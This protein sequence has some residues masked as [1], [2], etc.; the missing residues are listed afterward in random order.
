MTGKT[1]F[2]SLA[3]VGLGAFATAAEAQVCIGFPNQPAQAAVALSSN[4]P[5]D[6]DQF[7]V[8]GSMNLEGPLAV[9]A[10][11]QRTTARGQAGG[12][13]NT[14]RAG[15]ALEVTERYVG[16]FALH[17]SACPTVSASLTRM[18]GAEVWQVPLGVGIG[19]RIEAG[20][21]G[22][23]EFMPYA[24]PQLVW[25]RARVEQGV[26]PGLFD[27]L[28]GRQAAVAERE[29]TDLGLRTGVL[30]GAGRLYLGGEYSNVFNDGLG[31]TFGVKAGVRF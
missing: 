17:L 13:A 14:F 23:L 4:F 24:V 6:A 10:G 22:T 19:G 12:H 15:A 21:Q 27:P 31:G 2:A 18:E 16:P 9:H 20:P 29:Q 30:V 1:L 26:Q 5:A 25:T 8:E 11:Y 7:G 3:V 28:F